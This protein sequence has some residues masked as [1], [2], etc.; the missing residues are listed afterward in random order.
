MRQLLN[1]RKPS[2]RPILKDFG[3]GLRSPSQLDPHLGTQQ[4]LTPLPEMW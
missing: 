2:L 1:K 4:P 3:F